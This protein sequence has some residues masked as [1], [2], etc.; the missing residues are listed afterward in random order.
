MLPTNDRQVFWHNRLARS[1]KSHFHMKAIL[2]CNTT[3]KIGK[4]KDPT[5]CRKNDKVAI[6]FGASQCLAFKSDR[7]GEFEKF[8]DTRCISILFYWVYR[9]I[10]IQCLFSWEHCRNCL[11][12]AL[13]FECSQNTESFICCSN[14]VLTYF[15]SQQERVDCN[16][17]STLQPSNIKKDWVFA[18]TGEFI[19]RG[20][21]NRFRIEKSGFKSLLH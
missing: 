20:N 7:N 1:P 6:Y 12:S 4:R 13:P 5:F 2:K 16:L 19:F 15:L 17:S 11:Q 9:P 21:L 8:V 18:K 3:K 14:K 10:L